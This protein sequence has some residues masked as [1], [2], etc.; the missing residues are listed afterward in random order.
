M[1]KK[2]AS[3]V[4]LV[5][6]SVA[7]VGCDTGTMADKAK[8]GVDSGAGAAKDATGEMVPAESKEMVDGAIDSTGE[9]GKDAID[10]AVGK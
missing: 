4:C 7:F 5:V 2:F 1:L 6:L 8:D 9:A 3:I 10:G